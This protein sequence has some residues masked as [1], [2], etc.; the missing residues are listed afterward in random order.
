M[1][2]SIISEDLHYLPSTNFCLRMQCQLL[3]CG[4]EQLIHMG[5]LAEMCPVT[6]I[7]STLIVSARMP[8]G[9]WPLYIS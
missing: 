8:L 2:L 7:W 4:V 5:S 6:Y 1:P 3:F 9:A